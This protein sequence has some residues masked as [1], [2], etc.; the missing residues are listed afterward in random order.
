MLSCYHYRAI[1]R[2]STLGKGILRWN[3]AGLAFFFLCLWAKGRDR[4]FLASEF[5]ECAL[6]CGINQGKERTKKLKG[7][8]SSKGKTFIPDCSQE[9]G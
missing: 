9:T 6:C 1:M 8:T 7:A 3:R 2:M 5:A 4:S